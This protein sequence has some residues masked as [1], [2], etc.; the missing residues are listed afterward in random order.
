LDRILEDFSRCGVVGEETNKLVGYL[1]AV[2]RKLDDP[3][4]VILQSS[5]AAGKSSLMDAILDL[6]PEEE[7][8]AYSAMTGQSLFYMGESDLAHKVL[9]VAEEEGAERASYALKLLQSEG[10]L[11]IA[12]TGKDPQTGRL[13][14]HEYR[15]EG[16][17]AIFLTTTAI[18]VDEELLNRCLVLTVNETREQTRAIHRLQRERRTLE[19]LLAGQDREAIVRRHRNA[20]RLLRPLPVA[21]PYAPALTF[22]DTRTRTRRDH[23]KYLALIDAVALLHQHQRKVKTVEHRGVTVEYLEVELGDVELANRLAGEVLGRS[24]DELPPQTRRLLEL[25]DRMVAEISEGQAIERPRVR[26]TRRQVRRETGWR[27][28]Q[29]RLHLGRLVDMEYVVVHQGGR[30][31]SFLYEL[32][33]TGGEAQAEAP[34]RFLPGLIDVARL[35]EGLRDGVRG[36]RAYD[37]NFAGSGGHLAGT[38]PENAPP[39][40]PQRGGVAGGARGEETAQAAGT[41][42]DSGSDS[43]GKAHLED[44]AKAG[45]SRTP[46]LPFA[47][48]AG[49][50]GGEP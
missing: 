50:E 21:N 41:S 33:Y 20:Q 46:T 45:R 35:R 16:P 38:E 39:T 8:V 7:R 13:V 5:S 31:R 3:L 18:D 44:Q 40:R 11:T 34:E 27:D 22:L 37:P 9:A 47:A 14:T 28:T 48:S 30:G 29:L 15:V 17:V 25:L 32:V 36:G 1:A 19:G 12:S 24:L 42:A 4:A 23:A 2:S 49:R 26:F 43:A 10:E 6:V